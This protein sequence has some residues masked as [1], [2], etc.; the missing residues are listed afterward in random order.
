VTDMLPGTGSRRP[1]SDLVRDTS[2]P[3][4]LGHDLERPELDAPA[5][6]PA[7]F[8]ATGAVLR[9][10]TD[11][12]TAVVR[13]LNGP[14]ADPAVGRDLVAEISVL[15][16]TLAD[17]E[18]ELHHVLDVAERSAHRVADLVHR[19][20]SARAGS[21]APLGRL[22]GTV[23]GAYHLAVEAWIA[24]GP[25]GCGE[26]VVPPTLLDLPSEL[27]RSTAELDELAAGR[28]KHRARDLLGATDLLLGLGR[29]VGLLVARLT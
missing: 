26:A 29:D 28:S 23:S 18:L 1:P 5:T 27:V 3:V 20:G 17:D 10:T 2:L 19:T 16:D 25:D 24:C 7:A 4:H 6:G 21:L 9:A 13:G 11:A 15:R 22:G 8:A 14:A 12:V